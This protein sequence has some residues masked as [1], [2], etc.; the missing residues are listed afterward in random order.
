MAL[1]PGDG[2]LDEPEAQGP[3]G[4]QT[5]VVSADNQHLTSEADMMV[6]LAEAYL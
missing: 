4:K 3:H 6:E 2:E 1:E 5:R